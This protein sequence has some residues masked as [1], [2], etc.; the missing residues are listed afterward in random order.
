MNRTL[1][2]TCLILIGLPGSLIT[3]E[4]PLKPAQPSQQDQDRVL[5]NRITEAIRQSNIKLQEYDTHRQTTKTNKK[6]SDLPNAGLVKLMSSSQQIPTLKNKSL[7]DLLQ[8]PVRDLIN[9]WLKY[10]GST[11]DYYK[12]ELITQFAKVN[13]LIASSTSESVNAPTV[14]DAQRLAHAVSNRDIAELGRLFNTGIDPNLTIEAF[15]QGKQFKGT[16]LMFA[17]TLSSFP[18]VNSLLKNDRLNPNKKNENGTTPLIE[19]VTKGEI[20][21]VRELLKN[22][23]VLTGINSEDNKKLTALNYAFQKQLA[24]PWKEISRML[25]E[26]GAIIGSSE[27]NKP[28]IP[29]AQSNQRPPVP[30]S[31]YA[32][33]GV[34]DNASPHQILNI[35][36]GATHEEISKAY[37]QL[38]IKWH[39][40]KNQGNAE[41]AAIFALIKWAYNMLSQP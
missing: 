32:R 36:N 28:N 16:V 23:H 26:K 10:D 1:I 19:A 11:T 5:L 37:R 27:E 33:L 18:L 22:P 29:A 35:R 3:M 31:A 7:R 6:Q 21:I 14:S 20:E 30:A 4:A 17:V 15:V 39:P 13:Q 38:A 12:P 34:P 41:A 2:I 40:D 24:M 25:L 9:A 8:Q